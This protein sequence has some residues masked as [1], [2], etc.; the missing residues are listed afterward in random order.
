MVSAPLHPAQLEG[1][2]RIDAEDFTK[3][4]QKA[5][6]ALI[7]MGQNP[8][9]LYLDA[10]IQGLKLYYALPVLDPGNAHAVS[11]E[12]DVFWH[13][14]MLFSREYARFSREVVGDMIHHAPLD[15][16]DSRQLQNARALHNYTTEALRKLFGEGH[17]DNEVWPRLISDLSL[18]WRR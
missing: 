3:V 9:E 5:K 2:R 7:A 17:I 12:I 4:R 8:S 16:S 10:G 11:P 6:E 15:R 14:H 18:L 1:L 13:A